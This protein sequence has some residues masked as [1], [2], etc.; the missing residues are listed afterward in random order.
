MFVSAVRSVSIWHGFCKYCEDDH[1][2]P[3]TNWALLLQKLIK[4]PYETIVID[5]KEFLDG[6]DE[7]T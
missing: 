1:R 4:N 7:D 6:D 5:P 2:P 3:N